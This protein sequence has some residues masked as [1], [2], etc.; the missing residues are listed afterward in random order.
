MAELVI[1]EFIS[2]YSSS[3]KV[4]DET[5]AS[6]VPLVQQQQGFRPVW[7]LIT[8]PPASQA[9]LL[10]FTHWHSRSRQPLQSERAW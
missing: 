9:T 1:N 3:C 6:A 5:P 8:V 10:R 4:L 2:I 7:L